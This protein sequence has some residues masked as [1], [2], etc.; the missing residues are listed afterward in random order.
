[1]ITLSI[2][3]AWTGLSPAAPIEAYFELKPDATAFWSRA[4]LSVAGYTTPITKTVAI[5]VPVSIV[6]EFLTLIA[7]TPLEEGDYQ[8]VMSHTDDYPTI[9]VAIETANDEVVFVS[10]S[11]GLSHVPWGALIN[12]KRYITYANTL[13]RAMTLLD[14]YLARA[15]RDELVE[16]AM[17]RD[18]EE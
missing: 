4:E 11:Q 8:P 6:D 13:A 14:P 7:S 9:A 5:S 15:E 10:K 1:M 17:Q 18:T 16:R 12:Q 3:D 2:L